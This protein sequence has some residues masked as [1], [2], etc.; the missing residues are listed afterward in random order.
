MPT[1]Q[2]TSKQ[3]RPKIV[4]IVAGWLI[5]CSIVG[6]I[7]LSLTIPRADVIQTDSEQAR[8]ILGHLGR[9]GLLAVTLVVYLCAGSTGVGLWRLRPW[10]RVAILAVSGALVAAS[11]IVGSLTAVREHAFDINSVVLAIVFGWP[12]FYFNREKIKALFV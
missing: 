4:S 1:A 11:F 9:G 3:K 5:V 7:V 10:G 8:W 12:L 2:A 6:A